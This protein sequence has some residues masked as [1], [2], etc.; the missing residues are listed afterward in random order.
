MTT[1]YRHIDFSIA[2][3]AE[4]AEPPVF[5][6]DT[7]TTPFTLEQSTDAVFVDGTSPMGLRLT[8][9]PGPGGAYLR[10]PMPLAG[11]GPTV[12]SRCLLA[13]SGLSGGRLQVMGLWSAAEAPLV[14]VTLDSD[15]NRLALETSTAQSAWLDLPTAITWHTVELG[16]KPTAA[17]G[18]EA[19]LWIN[20]TLRA[21]VSLT[22]TDVAASAWLGGIEPEGALTGTLDLAHWTIANGEIGVQHREPI[23]PH[24]DDPAR[25][26]VV[27]NRAVDDADAWAEHYRAARGVPYANLCGLDLPTAE[28]LDQAEYDNMHAQVIDYL[29]RNALSG[30][31]VGLLLGYGVPGYLDGPGGTTRWPITALLHH[32]SA[33]TL[34]PAPIFNPHYRDLIADRPAADAMLGFRYTGRIDGPDLAAATDLIDRA[35]AVGASQL[36]ATDNRV[37][38]DP[39]PGEPSVNPIFTEPVAAWAGSLK[40]DR[41]RLPVERAS[42]PVGH[43]AVSSAAVVWGWRHTAPPA[44]FFG[45]GSSQAAACFQLRQADP[46]A[47]SAR[48]AS[49][50]DWMSR[51]VA[52]GYAAAAASAAPFSLSTLPLPTPMFDALRAGWTLAE[53]WLVAQPFVRGGLQLLGDPL[54]TVPFP[55]AGY[56]VLGPKA[57]LDQIDPDAPLA[58][59]PESQTDLALDIELWQPGETRQLWVRSIGGTGMSDAATSSI[60]RQR[61]G[62]ALLP[63]PPSPA[64]PDSAGW[65]VTR[66]AGRLIATLLWPAA[67]APGEVDRVELQ[68][69]SGED[70]P[71]MIANRTG[72]EL[73]HRRVLELE[74]KPSDAPTRYRLV[75]WR[76]EAYRELPWSAMVSPGEPLA[77]MSTVL[78]LA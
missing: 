1:L 19:T 42:E 23:S 61:V 10:E 14:W 67:I 35:T 15:T 29:A 56:D 72:A 8:C 59:L 66:R 2:G 44:G 71:I 78:E 13:P 4:L 25:W 49:A 76:G 75:L 22:S 26:L 9:T 74:I 33:A 16:H 5:L 63:P 62:D 50:G 31:V 18:P 55:K 47:L 28:A 40:P 45:S 17:G 69:V 7:Q 21:Q 46:A 32:D 11:S 41:L 70:E 43:D 48:D 30:Q 24:A 12:H 57:R 65:Q 6:P 3:F 38:I 58:V 39:Y 36:S 73:L 34:N 52:A 20:G 77:T 53:A 27:Y 68:A 54:M 60:E 64:W 51:A 37:W